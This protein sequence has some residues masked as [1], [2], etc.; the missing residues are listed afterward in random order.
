MINITKFNELKSPSLKELFVKEIEEMIISGQLQLGE[1]LP[2][3]R[4]LAKSMNVSR[5][6]I[7]AGIS[8][9]SAKGFLEVIPRQGTFITDYKR[10]GSF[11]ILKSI[12]QYQGGK[13]DQDIFQSLM[14]VRQL[15]EIESASLAAV[16]RTEQD[17]IE[18]EEI[19]NG[20][21]DLAV[22]TPEFI[23][24]Q[25]F[26]FHY[27]ITLASGNILYALLMGTFEPLCIE[28]IRKYC[29]SKEHTEIS[30]I[31]HKKLFKA[32]QEKDAQKASQYM[33]QILTYGASILSEI[34]Y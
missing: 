30:V 22:Q 34:T 5:S 1:R 8:E 31:N 9:L 24:E 7:N 33:K 32:I 16:N 21:M 12:M 20:K 13:I 14:A 26:L 11:G 3:E 15:I 19:I 17:L 27:K 10:N 28:L 2:P 18:L 29:I 25:N 4:E 23:A 6:V